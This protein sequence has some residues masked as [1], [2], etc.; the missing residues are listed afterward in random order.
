[1]SSAILLQLAEEIGKNAF[2]N[3]TRSFPNGTG[4]RSWQISASNVRR[5]AAAA[6]VNGTLTWKHLVKVDF[7]SALAAKEPYVLRQRLLELAATVVEFIQDLDRQAIL[8]N[9][10]LTSTKEPL[11]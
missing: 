5:E 7:H 8:S 11:E 6:A 3:G 10:S 4:Y 1:M 2:Q 9:A